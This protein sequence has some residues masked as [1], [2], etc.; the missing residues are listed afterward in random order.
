[1]SLRLKS[2]PRSSG[3][4]GS[5]ASLRPST[6]RRFAARARRRRLLSLRPLLIG[7]ALVGLMV[8]MGWLVLGSTFLAVHKV[9][10]VGESR[11]DPVEI[12]NAA[13]VPM[14]R[15]LALLDVAAIQRRVEALP[16]V[17]SATVERTWPTAVTITVVE[18]KAAAV[19]KRPGKPL[20][21]M[22][23]TG[24]VF[25]DVDEAPA[26]MAVLSLATPGPQD[27]ATIAALDV[28]ESL[29]A[30][31]R[32][33]VTS[34]SAPTPASVTLTLTSGIT[35]IWG[36]ASNSARKAQELA[37]VLHSQATPPTAAGAT[38]QPT[39][40]ATAKLFDLSAPNVLTVR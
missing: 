30:K 4:M 20:A 23:R 7:L 21:L 28:V 40:P 37:A 1:M 33:T 10:V 6:E 18:R 27:L 14:N 35:V 13:H 38:A 17:Q 39:V 11:L 12:E 29:P 34:V 15:P 25:S 31:V 8:A 5:N 19:V 24:V 32:A 26:G 2:R 22:D 36:D 16:P 9:T 3:T